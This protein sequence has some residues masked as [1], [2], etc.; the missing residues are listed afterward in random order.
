MMP[1]FCLMKAEAQRQAARPGEA[2]ASLSEGLKICVDHN[3]RVPEPELQRLKGEI[4]IAQGASSAGE[5]SLRRAIEVARA[6]QARMLELRA[7]LV[8]AGLLGDQGRAAEARAELEPLVEWFIEAQ[9]TPELTAA[10]A[11]LEALP[12]ST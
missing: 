10:R 3:E 8:L 4:Q 2:L 12:A 11:L 9:G 1:Q 7:A 6:Q 5:A